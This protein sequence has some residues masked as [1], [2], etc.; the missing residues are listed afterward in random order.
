MLC[1]QSGAPLRHSPPRLHEVSEVSKGQRVPWAWVR[2]WRGRKGAGAYACACAA[3]RARRKG[4]NGNCGNLPGYCTALADWPDSLPMGYVETRREQTIS[5]MFAGSLGGIVGDWH[6]RLWRWSFWK[7]L[8]RDSFERTC[9][10]WCVCVCV[11]GVV[12]ALGR[13]RGGR[14]AE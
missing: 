4:T 5:P 3:A 11:L 9:V 6:G 8:M 12:R 1:P 13:C 14:R 7:S 10:L 2:A